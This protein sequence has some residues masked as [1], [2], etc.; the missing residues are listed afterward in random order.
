MSC[1]MKCPHCRQWSGE[2][3]SVERD[4]PKSLFDTWTC[5]CEGKSVWFMGA[6][7]P[8]PAND[9]DKSIEWKGNETQTGSLCKRT[10]GPRDSE[11]H[12]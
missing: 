6:P 4:N 11:R 8:I 7:V 9:V 12:R 3:R 10:K 1:E 2:W 5:T